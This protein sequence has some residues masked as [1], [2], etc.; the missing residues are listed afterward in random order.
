MTAPTVLQQEL[1][2]LR[3]VLKA[4]NEDRYA[5]RASNARLRAALEGMMR[6]A[7]GRN[8]A[9]SAPQSTYDAARAALR[10]ETEA[11]FIGGLLP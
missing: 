1:A 11:G 9:P 10:A 4:M 5:L 8:I 7:D 6:V 2:E 3:R